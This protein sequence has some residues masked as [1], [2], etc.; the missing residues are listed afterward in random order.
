MNIYNLR[1]NFSAT[2]SHNDMTIRGKLAFKTKETNWLDTE[3]PVIVP[4]SIQSSFHEGMAGYLKMNAFISTIKA[5]VKGNITILFT[6]KAHLNVAS[7]RFQN[8]YQRTFDECLH[9]AY[10][11]ADR[12][13]VFFEGCNIVYWHKYI[14]HDPSYSFFYDKIIKIYQTDSVFQSHLSADAEITYTSERASEFIDKFLFISKAIEDLLEQCICVLVMA[15][16]GYRF[17]FYPGSQ[18]AS[19]EY[20][21]RMFVDI[22]KKLSFID[23]FLTIEKKTITE[24]H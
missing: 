19:V 23:V 2:Y 20:V 12:F 18:F 8:N 10:E 17:Q 7:L 1:K 6:E 13:K 22:E 15:N 9:Q 3:A 24:N 5:H 21:N 14:G 4:I 11:V 16:K